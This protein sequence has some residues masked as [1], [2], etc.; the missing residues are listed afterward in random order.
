MKQY[1]LFIAFLLFASSLSAQ[2]KSVEKIT[3]SSSTE[4]KNAEPSQIVTTTVPALLKLTGMQVQHA[5]P[6]Q[7]VTTTDPALL[8]SAA[9][10]Q[11]KHADPSQI[12]TET[13]PS[14]LKSKEPLTAPKK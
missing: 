12:T 11:V 14:A 4:V 2:E 1:T 6:S 9:S 3:I 5:N 8:K 10:M 13:D 7:I